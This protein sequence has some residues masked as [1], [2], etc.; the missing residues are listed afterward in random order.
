MKEKK[1]KKKNKWS[2]KFSQIQIGVWNC[3]A[4]SNERY[5]YCK[6]LNYDILGLTELHNGQT[7]KHFQD[8]RWVCSAQAPTQDG[9]SIDPAAG[10]AILLSNRIA[11]KVIDSGYVITSIE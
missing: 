5:Q 6:S 8:R 1:K 2:T 10:V 11:D 7:K 4:I 9:K 3:W